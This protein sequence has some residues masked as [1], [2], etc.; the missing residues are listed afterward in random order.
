[1]K[2]RCNNCMAVFDE[3]EIIYNEKSNTEACPHCGK[4]GRLMD[5]TDEEAQSDENRLNELGAHFD[6][7]ESR[8]K[9]IEEFGK[10]HTSYMG[11]NNHGE[12]VT[13]SISEDGIIER[14]WQDNHRVRVEEYDKEGYH[15]GESYDGRWT[16]DPMPIPDGSPLDKEVELSD[17][18]LQ[19]NDDIYAAVTK[20]CR[21]LTE[22]NEQEFNM[23]IVGPISD[24]AAM[25]LTRE[26]NKVRF[27]SVVQDTASHI[28][29]EN[30]Y[31]DGEVQAI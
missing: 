31:D 16:E 28:Y 24:Y 10:S 23:S 21:V 17:A 8:R 15:V 4:I 14:V 18:Q 20:M 1:M 9:L 25:L 2:V 13:L 5:L 6:G 26:G 12:Q 7:I 30:Y 19:R 29:I 3:P 11:I 27:P 22:N